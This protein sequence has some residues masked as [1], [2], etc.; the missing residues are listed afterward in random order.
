[1]IDRV[2]GEATIGG[3]AVGAMTLV[4]FPIVKAGRIHALSA[5][6]ALTTTSVDFHADALADFELV[7]SW[8]E[9]GNRAHIFVARRE[10]LVEGQAALNARRRAAVN[11]L[12]V[13]CADRNGV[14]ADQNLRAFWNRCGFVAQEKFVRV[15]QHPS[16]HLLRNR[17]FG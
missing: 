16:L 7:D 12:K 8:S 13:G 1:M 6:L 15:A 11:D 14:D 10:V 9:R 2:F 5:P 17:K 4:G 3:E